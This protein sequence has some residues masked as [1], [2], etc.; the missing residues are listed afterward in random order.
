[1]LEA[2]VW[3]RISAA[4]MAAAHA[5]ITIS[6]ADEADA[7]LIV[8]A[9]AAA[10]LGAGAGYDFYG[11]ARFDDVRRFYGRS[12]RLITKEAS[13]R[14][15]DVPP[16][17]LEWAAEIVE[18]ALP[19]ALQTVYDLGQ[20]ASLASLTPERLIEPLLAA[21]SQTG[22]TYVVDKAA[23][24]VPRLLELLVDRIADAIS[25]NEFT[26][27]RDEL[28]ARLDPL[29][30]YLDAN[31][32][33]DVELEDLPVLAGF[34]S[35]SSTRASGRDGGL[36]RCD[37]GA[38][39]RAFR[40]G[41]PRAAG[42]R[43][44]RVGIGRR[45]RRHER[46]GR[47]L[48]PRA[49]ADVRPR[50]VSRSAGPQ[51]RERRVPGCGR[52]PDGRG[53]GHPR[54]AASRRRSRARRPRRPFRLDR[55]RIRRRRSG[56]DLRRDL[57]ALP[58]YQRLRTLLGTGSTACWGR[59]IVPALQRAGASDEYLSEVAAPSLQALESFVLAKLDAVVEAGSNGAA[60]T[61]K[62]SAGCSTLV[63][64][65]V[66]RNGLFLESV[67]FEYVLDS[68]EEAFR[69]WLEGFAATRVTC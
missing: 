1:M 21:F 67:L 27:D 66:V 44:L 48:R 12:V 15:R 54:R 24:A 62:L 68:M 56:A 59:E 18:L 36:A 61:D 65:I 34:L 49:L 6:L 46:S 17:D 32:D 8:E 64:G 3:A 52:V 9:G 20:T 47:R 69:P 5:E 53:C 42:G 19:T 28:N 39:D 35:T 30:A 57:T 23:D 25:D 29:N 58:A 2:G 40:R 51:S 13:K 14:V 38:V 10:G 31:I 26:F 50:G 22:R 41:R 63:Y 45:A 33:R 60:F 37:G 16:Q 11:A 43:G 7:G 4:A 55:R